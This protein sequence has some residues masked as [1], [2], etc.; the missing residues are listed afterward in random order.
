MPARRLRLQRVDGQDGE[1]D[2]VAQG[3]P[4]KDIDD[5]ETGTRGGERKDRFSL[6]GGH[7]ERQV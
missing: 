1:A 5:V 7:F 2:G 4:A 6:R 3:T